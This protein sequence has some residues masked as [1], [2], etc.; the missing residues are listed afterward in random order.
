MDD[1]VD[2]RQFSNPDQPALPKPEVLYP[3]NVTAPQVRSDS[4]SLN[5]SVFEVLDEYGIHGRW[6]SQ[7]LAEIAVLEAEQADYLAEK[8]GSKAPDEPDDET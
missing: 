6:R 8:R 1:G 5:A 4:A 7:V 3:W 2:I